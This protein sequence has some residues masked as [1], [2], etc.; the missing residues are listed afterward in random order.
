MKII[1]FEVIEK[2]PD[3]EVSSYYLE[4]FDEDGVEY[5]AWC[6]CGSWDA[7]GNN[8]ADITEITTI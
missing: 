4:G 3:R 8:G 6:D 2:F 5:S 7:F 1:K